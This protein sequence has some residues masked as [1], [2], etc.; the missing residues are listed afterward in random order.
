MRPDGLNYPVDVDWT[1]EW[2]AWTVSD[3]NNHKTALKPLSAPSW[4]QP[5]HITFDGYFAQWTDDGTLLFCTDDG[6]ALLDRDGKALRRFSLPQG[7]DGAWA[8][9]RRY[10]HR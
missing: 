3:G 4:A 7:T 5:A 6:M 8:S 2:V 10:G 9:H 1:G